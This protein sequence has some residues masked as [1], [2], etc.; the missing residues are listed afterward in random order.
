MHRLNSLPRLD[1]A[2]LFSGCGGFDLGFRQVGFDICGAFDIDPLAVGNYRANLQHSADVAD[3]ANGLPCERQLRNLGALLA[4]P[5]C[6][7]FSTAG[8]RNLNDPRNKLLTLTGEIGLRLRPRVIVVEN[9]A[10]AIAGEH[11]RYWAA[12]VEMLRERGYRTVSLRCQASD[13]GMAQLRR[14]IVLVAWLGGR[15]V[16]FDLPK[17]DPGRLSDALSGVHSAP[18]HHPKPLNP[19]SRPSRIAARI[20]PGQ[21]LSNV[22]SSP[23]AV[24]TW[25]IPEVFGHTNAAQRSLLA[26][27]LRLRRRERLRD[28]GDADPVTRGRLT[29]ELGRP[30][31]GLAEALLAKGYLRKIGRR[32]DLAHTFNG[33]FRRLQWSQPSCTV[34]TRFG[35][36]NFFLHPD[37]NRG[38][39]VREAARLQGFPDSYVFHG[40]EA[41]QFRLVGN[42]VPPPLARHI[43][44]FVAHLLGRCV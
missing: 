2:S 43:A 29:R 12:L 16:H 10:G 28:F 5:P 14:R 15:E 13:F 35:D 7:G 18:N 1:F 22:R 33:K 31:D 44:T 42:A 21:K 4:G 24:H 39:T 17:S 36:P 32:L 37:E 30:I 3:L 23:S 9:V 41:S 19:D 40:D 20:R 34:D 26:A 27:L 25:D 38:F 11:G 6:Q 8:K